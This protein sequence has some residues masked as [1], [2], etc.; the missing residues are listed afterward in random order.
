MILVLEFLTILL[1][2]SLSCFFSGAE[3]SLLKLSKIKVKHWI[4][5]GSAHSEA[6]ANWLSKPEELITTILFGNT[7]V[8]IFLS[9][10]TVVFAMHLF[11]RQNN[12]IVQTFAGATAFFLILIFGEIVPKIYCRQNAEKIS[13]VALGPLFKLSKFLGL[14]LEKFL[15]LIGKFFPIFREP[16]TSRLSSLTLDEI[17]AIVLDSSSLKSLPKEHHE[18]MKKV[19]E[20]HQMT[21]SQIMTPWKDVDFLS[22]NEAISGK[23]ETERFIDQWIESGRTRLP[24]IMQYSSRKNEDQVPKIVG[25]LHVKDLIL[26]VAQGRKIEPSLFLKWVRPLPKIQSDKKIGE[27]LDLFRFGSPIASVRDRLDFP[28]G[29]LTLED[30]LEEIVGEILDEYDLGREQN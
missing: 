21:V 7:L 3:T 29:I 10:L 5:T 14:P 24:V 28:L 17:R 22:M 11:H 18:M 26:C 23:I 30:I 12:E 9:S 16:S 19:L 20:I 27:V 2:L 25:Y 13:P 4:H 8:N 6:W 1:L 15:Q